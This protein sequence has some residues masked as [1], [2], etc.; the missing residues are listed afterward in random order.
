MIAPIFKSGN[1]L[2][3]G[4]YRGICVSSY[5]G[6]LFSSILNHRIL[7]FT[8][9][10]NIIHSSQ[11]G[12]LR[13]NRTSGHIITPR[14]L[15]RNIFISKQKVYAGFV[16]FKKAFDSVWHEDLFYRILS[17]GI[18]NKIYDLIKA[19]YARSASAIKI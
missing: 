18:G 1:K 17:Y 14:A 2:D 13:E 12:F 7:D 5:L 9:N 4:N 16:D 15:L 6:K 11:V 19:L 8:E 3:P 10:K